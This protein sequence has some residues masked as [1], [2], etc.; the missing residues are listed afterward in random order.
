MDMLRSAFI[1]SR[2][3]LACQIADPQM[4]TGVA[5]PSSSSTARRTVYSVIV[6][7]RLDDENL[8]LGIPRRV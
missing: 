3:S 1:G 2:Y 7:H 8:E 5:P 4:T 6:R